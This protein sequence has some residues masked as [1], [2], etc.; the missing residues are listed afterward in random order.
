MF[1]ADLIKRY[2]CDMAFT[3]KTITLVVMKISR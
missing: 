1:I 2:R 3:Y